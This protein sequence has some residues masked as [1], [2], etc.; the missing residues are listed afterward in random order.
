M[1]ILTWVSRKIHEYRRWQ[2]ADELGWKVWA[3]LWRLSGDAADS[4]EAKWRIRNANRLYRLTRGHGNPWKPY[5][6]Y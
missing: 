1:N 3:P 2:Q 6:G 4:F 5:N